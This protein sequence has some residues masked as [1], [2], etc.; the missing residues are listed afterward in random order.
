MEA[1]ITDLMHEERADPSGFE[2]LYRS[3]APGVY[4]Y[5]C[6]RMGDAAVAEDVLHDVFIIAL[7]TM[8][9]YR[10]RAG[11]PVHHWLLRIATNAANRE[12][13][14]DLRRRMLA[15]NSGRV[16]H[17]VEVPDQGIALIRAVQSLPLSQQSAVVLHHVEGLSIEHVAGVLGCRIG[18]VKSRLHRGRESLRNA[19]KPAEG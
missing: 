19:L 10:P 1:A 6:R 3:H 16:M 18:T 13:R 15:E 4:R 2:G 11:V 7:R 8:H 9:R 14:R 17:E 5:L 12:L